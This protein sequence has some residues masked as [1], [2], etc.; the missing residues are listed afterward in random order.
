MEPA[1]IIVLAITL[2]ATSGFYV[3][4]GASGRMLGVQARSSPVMASGF[5][6]QEFFDS[7]QAKLFPSNA[8]AA[9]RKYTLEEIEEYCRDPDSSGCDLDMLDQMRANEARAGE[10]SSPEYRWSAEIDDAVFKTD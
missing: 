2:A 6:F 3:A 10:V 8:N 4:P 7:M 1:M 5:D 9:E